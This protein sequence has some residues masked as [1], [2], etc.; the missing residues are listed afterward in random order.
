MVSRNG[1]WAYS[2]TRVVIMS[3][4]K[5]VNQKPASK[6]V[7]VKTAAKA[8]KKDNPA[9]ISRAVPNN[10]ASQTFTIGK[11]AYNPRAAHNVDS[12]ERIQVHLAKGGEKGVSGEILAK[13]LVVNGKHPDR[14]HFDFI[15]YLER[16]GALAHKK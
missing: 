8:V 5:A 7:P 3:N 6:V 16:R 2:I 13:E 4:P 1:Q 15:S 9:E 14:T 11:A 12:W 10:I